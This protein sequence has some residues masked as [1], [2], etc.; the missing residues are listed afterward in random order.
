[1]QQHVNWTLLFITFFSILW[2]TMELFLLYL[3]NSFKSQKFR[4]T[5]VSQ[6]SSLSRKNVSTTQRKYQMRLSKWE[7]RL[8]FKIKLHVN[9]H[10]GDRGWMMC[11][12]H[13]LFQV[14]SQFFLYSLPR[15]NIYKN[16]ICVSMKTKSGECWV[17]Y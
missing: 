5:L 6:Y 1:M 10:K 15:H 13:S 9:K 3:M 11:M 2:I 4:F 7:V 8:W 12:R 17:I 14:K 16:R